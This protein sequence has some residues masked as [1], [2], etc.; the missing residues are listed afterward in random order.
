MKC[1]SIQTTSFGSCKIEVGERVL[2]T[3]HDAY[4]RQSFVDADRR[5]VYPVERVS[6]LNVPARRVRV[7]YWG[8]MSRIVALRVFCEAKAVGVGG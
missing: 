4:P 3:D 1:S 5:E 7:L 2:L 8:I 6:I